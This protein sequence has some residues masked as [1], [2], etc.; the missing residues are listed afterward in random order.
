MAYSEDERRRIHQRSREALAQRSQ[1]EVDFAIRRVEYDD[2]I[3]DAE[4]AAWKEVKAEK[5]RAKEAAEAAAYVPIAFRVQ[6]QHLQ[7]QFG[8]KSRLIQKKK[9]EVIFK[10]ASGT[11]IEGTDFVLSTGEIDRFGDIVDPTGW[12]LERF[13]KNPIA[14]YCHQHQS[15]IGVWEDLHVKNGALKGHLRLADKG[16]SLFHDEIRALVFQKILKAT[17]VGFHSLEA[18]PIK[19]GM[20]YTKMELVEVSV[21]TIPANASALAISEE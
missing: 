17:S 11:V 10:E 8:L 21:V 3:I 14:L 20:R 19:S 13:A 5:Q 6:A 9:S 18:T 12:Q 15:P 7:Q 2:A 16:T 1:Q 4:I